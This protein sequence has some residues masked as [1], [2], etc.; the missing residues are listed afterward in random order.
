M[1]NITRCTCSINAIGT[2]VVGWTRTAASNT[3]TFSCI[4]TLQPISSSFGSQTGA[5]AWSVS[6]T[7]WATAYLRCIR[8][9]NLKLRARVSARTTSYGKSSAAGNSAC[10]TF[11]SVTGSRRARR[12]RTRLVSGLSRAW[13]DGC[14]SG[15]RPIGNQARSELLIAIKGNNTVAYAKAQK[16]GSLTHLCEIMSFSDWYDICYCFVNSI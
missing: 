5:C 2:Q 15:F 9:L 12:W 13:W 8:S 14:G 10:P 1:L 7:G 16:E 11:T 3:S 4:A 6:S